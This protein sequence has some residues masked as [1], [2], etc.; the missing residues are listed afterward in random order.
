M[1]LGPRRLLGD[2]RPLLDDDP[3]LGL[4][5]AGSSNI[6]DDFILAKELAVGANNLELVN[7]LGPP[8]VGF[9]TI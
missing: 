1:F 5:V 7:E 9:G 6:V 2:N 4:L 8:D 3:T